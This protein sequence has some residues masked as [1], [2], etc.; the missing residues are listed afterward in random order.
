MSVLAL[1]SPVASADRRW[2]SARSCEEVA[3]LAAIFAARVNVCVLRR[4]GV[5]G[6]VRD[7]M[8]AVGPSWRWLE[9]VDAATWNGE[10]LFAA[11]PQHAESWGRRSVVEDVRLWAEVLGELTGAQRVG[12]R[13]QRL[14]APMCPRFHVDRV[15][16]RLVVTYL[17]GGTEWLDGR[18]VD[19]RWLGHAA[20]G[21]SDE[22]SG[23]IRPGGTVLTAAPG[24]V[25]L[26]KGEAWP[27]NVGRGAV[28][29]SPAVPEGTAR[30]VLTI[31]P[32]A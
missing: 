19:R 16:L 2:T 29:R 25:V 32:L 15:T 11:L 8:L 12:I 4:P 31:D 27:G 5:S 24:D 9:D 10:S 28:H 18:D 30:V 22:T 14:D 23:L 1:R 26:L 13:L 17:G 20:C 21:A 3:D 7:A 6:F